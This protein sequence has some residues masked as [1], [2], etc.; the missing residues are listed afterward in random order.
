MKY[1]RPQRTP[2]SKW[3]LICLAILVVALGVTYTQRVRIRAFAARLVAPRLPAEEQ[4][5]PNPTQ[6]IPDRTPTS[7]IKE[8]TSTAPTQTTLPKEK[9]LMVPF[10]VQAPKANWELPYQ[11]A[12]EEASVLMVAGY[13]KGDRG[14]YDADEADRMIREVVAFQEAHYGDYKDTTAGETKRFL[15]AMYPNLQAEVVPLKDAEQV[16]RYIA[17]G[18]PVI[19]PAD[20][21]QLPNPNFRNGGPP[22]HMLVVRGYTADHFITNDPGTRNGQNFLYTYDGLLD[23]VHDWNGGDVANGKRVLLIVT[24]RE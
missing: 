19:V 7:S 14:A 1:G 2:T 23:A 13:Y 5:H 17:E 10:L 16:K 3:P 22:F 6:E 20:G 15:E 24:P 21:K 12:C 9:R 18:I 8:P 4:Y 11:E